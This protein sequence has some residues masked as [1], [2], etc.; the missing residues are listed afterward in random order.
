MGA[1]SLTNQA[2]KMLRYI[3][4]AA[5]IAV[6]VAAETSIDTEALTPAEEAPVMDLMAAVQHLRKHAAS[7]MSF[8]VERI[9][10]HASLMQ[11]GSDDDE[12][13]DKAKSYVHNFAASKAA[14]TE[15]LKGLSGQLNSGHSHD[16]AALNSGLGAGNSAISNGESSGKVKTASFKNKAC[17]TK[18]KET[19][20]DAAKK[21]AK[22]A[23]QK[24]QDTKMCSSGIT[25]TWKD[26]DVDKSSPKFGTELRNKWDK[27][28]SDW[29]KAKETHDAA[30][31]A[32]E[33][34]VTTHN[35]SM[36]AFKTACKLEAEN[37]HNACKNAHAEYA[38]LKKEVA[39]NVNM[40]K[41]V[42]RA[43][44]V[45]H[46]YVNHLTDNGAAK[47]CGDKAL[48]GSTSQW[49][50]TPANL[51]ACKSTSHLSN[52]FGST[53]WL[54]TTSSCG[55]HWKV[56]SDLL[57]S[58]THTFNGMDCP[59]G[60]IQKDGHYC[61]NRFGG[62]KSKPASSAAV[63]PNTMEKLTA[64]C[65]AD[66]QCKAFDV[67]FGDNKYGHLCNGEGMGYE[68]HPYKVYKTCIHKGRQSED[69]TL[70]EAIQQDM[71]EA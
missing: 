32:H 7:H 46:C 12:S 47:A 33:H 24:I 39:S 25:E 49:D 40:R 20:A 18:K 36:A 1:K 68:L 64:K 31:K 38:V 16:K 17:P 66:P 55:G 59:S 2:N 5:F 63:S 69:I 52:S 70:V 67:A 65:D 34:A 42:H 10:K 23:M 8:H 53:T 30:V 43:I 71:T 29:I 21:A 44:G 51:P 35:L 37:A 3:A 60:Y 26:M 11:T 28:R 22:Q 62:P 45:V 48:K 14:I 41:H 13:D 19:E 61:S 9:A 4:I 15:A 50:I 57:E 54:P 58:E 56:E 6:A 27:A